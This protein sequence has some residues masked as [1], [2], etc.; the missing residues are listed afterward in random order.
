VIDVIPISHNDIPPTDIQ[1]PM[2]WSLRTL[3]ADKA[4][5]NALYAANPLMPRAAVLPFVVIVTD[6]CV[7]DERKICA[8]TRQYCDDARVL[9]FGIGSYCNWFFLKA[10]PVQA[11]HPHTGTRARTARHREINL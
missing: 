6:G 4:R 11:T 8:Y 9:T 7:E 2:E 5:L 1:A 10:R 3:A